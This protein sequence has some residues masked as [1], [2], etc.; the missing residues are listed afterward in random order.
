MKIQKA[1]NFEFIGIGTDIVKVNRF[2]EK[3]FDENKSF[4]DTIFSNEEIEYC[5]NFKDPYVHFAG[6]F[7]IKESVIK[8]LSE[9]ISFKDILTFNENSKPSIK[10]LSKNTKNY[11]FLVSMS[12]ENDY[13]IAV[14][15]V[16]EIY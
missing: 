11:N 7:A 8:S 12:H 2:R 10:L 3:I 6:K 16:N 4:Y 13:A 1:N 5:L 14:V 9:K 15:L